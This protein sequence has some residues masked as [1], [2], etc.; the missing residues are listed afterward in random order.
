VHVFL[1]PKGPKNTKRPARRYTTAQPARVSSPTR[2]V[3]ICGFRGG[4]GEGDWNP[5]LLRVRAGGSGSR[6]RSGQGWRCGGGSGG[7]AP[8]PPGRSCCTSGWGSK[9]GSVSSRHPCT[10][11]RTVGPRCGPAG[12]LQRGTPGVGRTGSRHV[13][14][15]SGTGRPQRQVRGVA[16]HGL[17]AGLALG[18]VVGAHAALGRVVGVPGAAAAAVPGAGPPRAICGSSAP[19]SYPA[20]RSW[21]GGG[22]RQCT[23]RTRVPGPRPDA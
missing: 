6:P 16:D 21:V 18:E 7:T 22:T 19:G 5:D 8:R 15:S 14:S 13:D 23:A 17:V 11:I 20:G 3:L 1:P 2:R 4:E 10:S 9:V 12:P